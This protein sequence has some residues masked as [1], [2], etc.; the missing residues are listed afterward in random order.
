MV[1]H[2]LTTERKKDKKIR[3]GGTIA[4]PSLTTRA[5]GIPVGCHRQMTLG[6]QSESQGRGLLM[7]QRQQT[8]VGKPY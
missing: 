6:R 8:V 5:I 4:S 3:G 2:R 1:E 7:D